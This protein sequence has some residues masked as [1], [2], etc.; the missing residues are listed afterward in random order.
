MEINE[1]F[2]VGRRRKIQT[3]KQRERRELTRLVVCISA[4]H[5]TGKIRQSNK[6]LIFYHSFIH[7]WLKYLGL[8][9]AAHLLLGSKPFIFLNFEIQIG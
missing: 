9:V 5:I 6:H 4:E 3:L 8:A 1:R 2:L 7:T